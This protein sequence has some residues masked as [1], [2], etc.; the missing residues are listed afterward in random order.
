MTRTDE[1]LAERQHQIDGMRKELMLTLGPSVASRPDLLAVIEEHVD[2]LHAILNAG[3]QIA[4]ASI[5]RETALAMA[6]ACVRFVKAQDAMRMVGAT[7]AA[8]LFTNVGGTAN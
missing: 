5:S 8:E 6:N 7:I 1:V 4:K 2:A 3:D